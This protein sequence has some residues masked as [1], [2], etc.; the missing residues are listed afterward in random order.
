MSAPTYE[1][2]RTLYIKLWKSLVSDPSRIGEIDNTARKIIA[3]KSRYQ[4]V[5]RMTT[6]PWWFIGVVHLREASLRFDLHL[7][8]GDPLSA[9]T[10]NVPAGRPPGNPPW[11]WEESA[12]DALAMKGF[13]KAG[14]WPIEA[15]A[16]RL[17]A[18]NGWGYW[19]SGFPIPSDQLGV[20]PYLWAACVPGRPYR[21]GKFVRDH[22]YDPGTVDR[23]LGC[24]PLL[25]RMAALDGSIK[26]AVEAPAS[27]DAPAPVPTP[28]P[29]PAPPPEKL[30]IAWLQLRMNELKITG[31]PLE[32]DGIMGARTVAALKAFQQERG[33]DPDGIP[34]PLTIAA[35][36]AT[37]APAKPSSPSTL[38]PR[39]GIASVIMAIAT[40]LAAWG[41]D[42]WVFVAC[43]LAFGLVLAVLVLRRK[44]T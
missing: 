11:T 8:N 7:H 34:G 10:R 36:R 31:A 33:L 13:D 9:K 29:I 32:V 15:V 3:R 40:A 16:F 27:P 6:V 30:D 35:L 4:A 19:S 2:A 25:Q 26:F 41:R 44:P 28:T 5:E 20:S 18:Y 23:Q 14:S 39:H 38:K 17:E 43:A 37:P 22:V 42:H 12:I 1:R 21:T 24:M